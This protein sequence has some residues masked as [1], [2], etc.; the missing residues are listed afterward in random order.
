M[1][2]SKKPKIKEIKS[3]IKIIELEKVPVPL[4]EEVKEEDREFGHLATEER[5]RF[6]PLPFQAQ[7]E[8]QIDQ[9]ETVA[10]FTQPQAR[11]RA[12][13]EKKEEKA[14][15]TYAAGRPGEAEGKTEFEREEERMRKY[16]STEARRTIAL[17]FE[18]PT[19]QR[20]TGR[21]AFREPQPGAVQLEQ[22]HA[23]LQ[24]GEERKYDYEPKRVE[25]QRTSRRRF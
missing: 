24:Q 13:A 18:R 10:E 6:T 17:P 9:Q 1:S 12:E 11:A 25:V 16:E 3:K 20:E 19:L 22:Q 5:A 21:G 4:E 8:Q 2:K 15:I 14:P 7:L 23:T